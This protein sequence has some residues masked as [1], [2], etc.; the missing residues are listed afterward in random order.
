MLVLTRR[1]GES[2]I[3]GNGVEAAKVK[4]LAVNGSTVRVGVEAPRSTPVHREEVYGAM[5]K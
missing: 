3:I 5:K 4:I 1:Q 2:I